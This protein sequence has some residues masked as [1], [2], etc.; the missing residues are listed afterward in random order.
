[1]DLLT[2]NLACVPTPLMWVTIGGNPVPA[3]ALLDNQGNP[4]L[5]NNGNYIL[6]N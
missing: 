4:I 3:N 2:I 1:M 6:Q 5:D